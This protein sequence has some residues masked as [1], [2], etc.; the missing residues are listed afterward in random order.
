[1][2]IRDRNKSS[3]QFLG[4]LVATIK[5]KPNNSHE[6]YNIQSHLQFVKTDG[7]NLVYVKR[8]VEERNVT[9]NSSIYLFIY[10]SP[11]MKKRNN[12]PCKFNYFYA[13]IIYSEL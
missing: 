7:E 5:S 11:G 8:K 1:M 6:W 12:V 13:I 9:L 10:S 3:S 2:C 4:N